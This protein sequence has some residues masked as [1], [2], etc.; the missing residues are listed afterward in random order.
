MA[1]RRNVIRLGGLVG[2][3][4]GCILVVA[5]PASASPTIPGIPDCKDAPT[6]QLPGNGLSGFLDRKPDLLPAPG[7]PFAD[8]MQDPGVSVETR[9]RWRAAW[10]LD[11][12][13]P[14]QFV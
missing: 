8:A 2:L 13:V 4:L 12:P 5:V 7:D 10:G 14:E 1:M 3:V 11:R 9:E 6:A